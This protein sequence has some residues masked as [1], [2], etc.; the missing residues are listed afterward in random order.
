MKP[1]NGNISWVCFVV[2]ACR[3]QSKCYILATNTKQI[4]STMFTTSHNNTDWL[5]YSKEILP[6]SAQVQPQFMQGL[7][8]CYSL[9]LCCEYCQQHWT[10]DRQK[11]DIP[12]A[13]GKPLANKLVSKLPGQL[14]TTHKQVSSTVSTATCHHN[15]VCKLWKEGLVLKW[16]WR[17]KKE[18]QKRAWGWRWNTM[19]AEIK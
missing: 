4:W 5:N 18:E 7:S 17:T 13:K 6:C 3:V 12:F 16:M 19:R 10:A 8:S 9:H 1:D 14:L 15:W 2:Q 11:E